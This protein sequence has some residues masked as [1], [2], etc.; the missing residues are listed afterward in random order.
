VAS[1]QPSKKT[2]L[3]NW[4]RERNQ[5]DNE[6]EFAVQNF[7]HSLS[8]Y[9]VATYILGISDRHNDNIMV[10]NSGHL[11]HIDFAHFLGNIMKFHGYKREK[12]PF[13][14]T[15]EFAHVMGG[16]KSNSFKW[17]TELCSLSYQFLRKHRNLFIILFSLMISTG[18]PELS[19][20]DDILYLRE[21]LLMD[22]PDEEAAESFKRLIQKSLKTKTT[23]VMFA[24]H[25]LAHP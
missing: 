9:C 23:Q 17:F 18:I 5:S 25:I 15:P 19:T 22:L 8:G 20:K 1:Q 6:Y 11:F 12:A 24:M 2:P 10:S 7:I 21:A 14:L 13:V 3:A 16:E 4:L